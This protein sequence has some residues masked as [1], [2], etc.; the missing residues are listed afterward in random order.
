MSIVTIRRNP[1]ADDPRRRRLAEEST[2]LRFVF[3]M[4]ARFYRCDCRV[5]RLR[6]RRLTL[7]LF[8][9]PMRDY[10][11]LYLSEFLA[12]GRC[13]RNFVWALRHDLEC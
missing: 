1:D 12:G 5:Y 3:L 2:A 11:D 6:C 4:D 7:T 13:Q 10:L 9:A 8:I